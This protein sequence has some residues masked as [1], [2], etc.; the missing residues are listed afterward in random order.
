[1]R[2]FCTSEIKSI[3]E[4]TADAHFIFDDSDRQR[5]LTNP[6]LEKMREKLLR[7]GDEFRG[8]PIF[9][10]PFSAFK[11][12]DIDGNRTEFEKDY[13]NRRKR[14]LTFALLSWLYGREDDIRELENIIWV[15][16]NEYTWAVPA[17]LSKTHVKD[18]VVTKERIGLKELQED[19]YTIDLFGAETSTALAETLSLVGDK[20][21]PLLVKRTE[22]HIKKRIFDCI[23]SPYFNWKHSVHN[24]S[25][26]CGGSCGIAAIYVERDT[27]RL[28][29][30]ISIALTAMENFCKGYTD[31]GG[32]LEGMGYWVYGF[33]HFTY[34]ADLLKRRTKGKI[35]LF[36]DEKVEKMAAFPQKCFLVGAK[37]VN[38]SDSGAISVF[39]PSLASFLAAEFDSVS[40]PPIEC[41]GLDNY[42]DHCARFALGVRD[43]VWTDENIAD[44]AMKSFGVNQ[45]PY[46]G[47]YIASSENGVGIA[48][49]AGCNQE[50]HNHND[51]G[52]FHV[53]K[54]G[55]MTLADVGSG[56]YKSQYFGPERYTHF[57]TSSASHNVP[58]INGKYQAYGAQ[59]ASR[60][61]VITDDGI[62]S[63]I[64]AAYDDETLISLKRSIRFDRESGVIGLID[65]YEFSESPTAVTERFV[66]F[67][68]PM[69][70]NGRITIGESSSSVILYDQERLVASVASVNYSGP[71]G[72]PM[73]A[74]T[75]DL[76]VINPIAK[77]T[78]EFKI[79]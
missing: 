79:R 68:K 28:A 15:I 70:D 18:G 45:F 62:T 50:P 48:A 13:F 24:W 16:L 67:E 2:Q 72:K 40:I 9:E 65:E 55:S 49:K 33:G 25:A 38:F 14:L 44:K 3:L 30:I 7:D 8:T 69:L 73:T 53:F 23:D 71:L 59:Y 35:N 52:S 47:W 1:M 5:V 32:C 37:K 12:H 17:H 41:I 46:A 19:G 77:F 66:S 4:K 10:I 11:R 54:N 51:T 6:H 60:D 75:I 58:I 21:T 27:E 43:F 22:L 64:A 74:Y 61:V 63:D 34:F 57:P 20:L 56:E 76:A 78:L 39:P 42:S 26:V 36:D 31:D 29:E